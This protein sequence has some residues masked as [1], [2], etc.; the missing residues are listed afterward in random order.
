MRRRAST[1]PN[2]LPP[3]KWFECGIVVKVGAEGQQ[4]PSHRCFGDVHAAKII[5]GEIAYETAVRDEQTRRREV[6]ERLFSRARMAAGIPSAADMLF[7]YTK[8]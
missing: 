7:A 2:L 3:D 8:G 4:I 5:T 6:E 1:E